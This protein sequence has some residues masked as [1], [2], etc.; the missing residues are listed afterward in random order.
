MGAEAMKIQHF[1]LQGMRSHALND[2]VPLNAEEGVLKVG[3]VLLLSHT[4]Q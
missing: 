3:G 4:E 1:L 2:R